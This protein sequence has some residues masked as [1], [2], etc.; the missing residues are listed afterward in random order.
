MRIFVTGATGWVGSALRKELI[1]AGHQVLGLTRSDKGAEALA[2]AGAE[3]H[4][5]SL[6]DLDSLKSGAAR[7]EAVIHTPSTMTSRNS[8]RTVRRTGAPSRRSAPCSKALAVRC[9]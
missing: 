1:G 6:S 2:A 5:G 7:S 4:R 9:S 8:Q 3:V